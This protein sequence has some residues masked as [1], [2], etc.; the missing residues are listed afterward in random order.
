M[1]V[2][3]QSRRRLI[4]NTAAWVSG[5]SALALAAPVRAFELQAISPGSETGLAYSN[6][7]GGSS[8]HAGLVSQLRSQL[9][10]NPSSSSMTATCPICGCPVTVSR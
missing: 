2:I 10:D 4:L 8:E 9:A 1:T 6:R 3:S 7:C 5:V